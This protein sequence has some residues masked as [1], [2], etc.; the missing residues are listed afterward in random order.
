[1]LISKV[2]FLLIFEL[3][4][5][6]FL[7]QSCSTYKNF[8]YFQDVPDTTKPVLSKTFPFKSPV[9]QKGDLL[10][11]T[12]QTLDND[13]T[14]LLNSSNNPIGGVNPSMPLLGS[15]GSGAATQ[16]P[17]G[18]Q[19]DN[20]GNVELPFVG[21]LHVE[22]LTTAQAKDIVSKE[23]SKYFNNAIINVRLTN[24]RITVLGEVLR[25]STFV[26]P[27]EKI[28]IFDA[29]GMAGDMTVF[30]RKD[31]VL[32]LRD[33]MN[34]KKI[35]RCNLNTKDIVN[36]PWFYLQPNDVIYVTPTKNKLAATDA[37]RNREITIVAAVISFLTLLV[38]R[39]IFNL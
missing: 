31:N 9:I 24:F 37:Y 21:S 33:T 18:Y 32:L 34:N 17:S 15:S 38:A 39:G 19:V 29:L 35:I 23:V 4:S 25:P 27:N 1:M 10:G 30:G 22:G 26:V 14:S 11:I 2:K 16:V 6:I 28:N 12:I 8:A 20:S 7:M 13:I 5:I 36:S 3:F